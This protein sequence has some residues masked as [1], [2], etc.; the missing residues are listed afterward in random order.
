MWLS[1]RVHVTGI[2]TQLQGSVS[3][4]G[5][6]CLPVI[7]LFNEINLRCRGYSLKNEPAVA[8]CSKIT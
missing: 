3:L 5:G 8:A 2:T 4:E 7:R 1:A 6:A